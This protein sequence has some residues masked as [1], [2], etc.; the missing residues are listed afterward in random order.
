MKAKGNDYT[1]QRA[2]GRAFTVGDFL[3]EHEWGYAIAY[4]VDAG[5]DFHEERHAVHPRDHGA[6]GNDLGNG[7]EIA[8]GDEARCRRAPE[9]GNHDRIAESRDERMALQA[10][11]DIDR[12]AAE[13]RLHAV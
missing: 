3:V 11:L 12:R 1:Q 13:I 5:G 8:L 6:S 9:I 10:G 4:E 2:P 7:Q